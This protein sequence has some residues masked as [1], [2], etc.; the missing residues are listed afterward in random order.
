MGQAK[1]RVNKSKHGIDFALARD[2]F[3]NPLAV[4]RFEMNY[5]EED[6]W[7][8]IGLV[9]PALII[10]SHIAPKDEKPG[11]IISARGVSRHERRACEEGEFQE[12]FRRANE[13]AQ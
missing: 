2:A 6:G 4:T 9:G 8:I 12:I 5:D 11:R 1:N 3:E 7:Q 10:E 13:D